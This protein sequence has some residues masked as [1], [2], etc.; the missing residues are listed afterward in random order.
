MS[1]KLDLVSLVSLA[2][3]GS[4]GKKV[5]YRDGPMLG[6]VDYGGK[7]VATNDSVFVSH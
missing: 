4:D 5:G 3:L 7:T 6:S 1:A 2:L